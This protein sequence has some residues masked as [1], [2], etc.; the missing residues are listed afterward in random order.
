MNGSIFEDAE[1]VLEMRLSR[2]EQFEE[3]DVVSGLILYL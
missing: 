3:T 2:E 1:M